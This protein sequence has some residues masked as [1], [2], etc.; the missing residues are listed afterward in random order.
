LHIT[1]VQNKKTA[2]N[3]SP[4]IAEITKELFSAMKTALFQP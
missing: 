3:D 2:K 1:T 4:R